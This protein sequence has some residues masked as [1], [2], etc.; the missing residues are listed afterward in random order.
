[1]AREATNTNEHNWPIDQNHD[2]L[3]GNG[4]LSIDAHPEHGAPRPILILTM[5]PTK[6]SILAVMVLKPQMATRQMTRMSS[7]NYRQQETGSP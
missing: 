1:M 5:I 2:E 7:R 4:K 3:L 6:H